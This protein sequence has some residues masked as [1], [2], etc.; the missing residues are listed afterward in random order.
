MI[1]SQTLKK[2]LFYNVCLKYRLLLYRFR[3]CGAFRLSLDAISSGNY[4]KP[5]KMKDTG[6]KEKY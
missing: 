5:I 3:A 6:T 2:A 4:E 1:F